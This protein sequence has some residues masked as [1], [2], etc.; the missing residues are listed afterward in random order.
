[1][2]KFGVD[3]IFTPDKP[4]F[5][6]K[7]AVVDQHRPHS[8]GAD[9]GDARKRDA[10]GLR[11]RGQPR[12]RSRG[13]ARTRG[14]TL[15]PALDLPGRRGDAA[16]QRA[17]RRAQQADRRGVAAPDDEGLLRARR[18]W[19]RRPRSPACTAC[20]CSTRRSTRW[21]PTSTWRC[22]TSRAARTTSKLVNVAIGAELNLARQPRRSRRRR[23]RATPATRR[24]ACSPRRRASS[25]RARAAR[26]RRGDA[27]LIDLFS[28]RRPQE[29]AGRSASTWVPIVTDR[30]DARAVRGR[31]ARPQG[32]GDAGRPEGARR[33]VGLRALSR[34]A[35]AGIRP[36]TRVL[37][38]IAATLAWGPLM[39]KRISRLTAESLPWWMRL[40]GTLI[41]ASVARRAARAGPLLR[42]C[43]STTSSASARSPRSRTS[44]CS[45]SSR[46]R[47]TCS[48]SRRWSA[49]C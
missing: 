25:G 1:M 36:R 5:S 11:A 49:C 12:A 13:S 41:G 10:A 22:C 37:A 28:A 24:T 14:S 2:E 39:R 23:R 18:R 31:R 38:A 33:E 21:R 30:R 44:P 46:S 8:G 16:V 17:D 26:A 40:F 45:G 27:A 15:P 42:H 47:R 7:G 48:R 3:G 29:R 4:V 19:T 6:A 35:W 43:R 9:R 20:R 32:R 34:R